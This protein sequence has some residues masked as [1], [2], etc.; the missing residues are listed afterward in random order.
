QRLLAAARRAGVLVCHVGFWTL[1]DHLSDSGPWLTQRRRSRFASDRIAMA[2]SDGAAFIDQLSPQV[3]EIEIR[4][5]RYSAFKGTNL[6]MVL[7]ANDI[8]T[9]IP[10]GVSTN[11]CVE[12]TL[13]DAFESGYYV[14]LPGDACASWDQSLHDATLKTADAR[15]GLVCKSTE[16]ESIWLKSAA[17][18]VAS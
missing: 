13:R 14:V 18:A 11:V 6:D 12:S 17:D 3:G 5:H 7:R 4:K 2:D 16:V 9:V 10:T 8:R 1:E 15:F